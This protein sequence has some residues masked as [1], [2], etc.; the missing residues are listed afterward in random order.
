MRAPSLS[1]SAQLLDKR[2]WTFAVPYADN[3]MLP[4]AGHTLQFKGMPRELV[5][6]KEKS[7]W[8]CSACAWLFNASRVPVQGTMD[9]MLGKFEEE[10]QQEFLRH[11]CFE[12]PKT[13]GRES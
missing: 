7:R 2:A 8:G 13:S 6:I 4:G 11:V 1:K 9:D 10:R 3:K 5:W 12:H